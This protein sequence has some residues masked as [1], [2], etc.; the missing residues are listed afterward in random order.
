MP[1]W[2]QGGE[3]ITIDGNILTL[4]EPL[5][6]D[7]ALGDHFISLRKYDGSVSGPWPVKPGNAPNQVVLQE[8]LDFEPYTGESQE[9]THI[10]FGVG[11]KWSTLA[12]VTSVRPRGDLVEINAVVE[13]QRVHSA[14]Q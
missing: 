6:W 10:A 14:D 1:S 9:R 5:T 11:E 2:G 12:R 3:I 7:H 4:S 13:N 8:K